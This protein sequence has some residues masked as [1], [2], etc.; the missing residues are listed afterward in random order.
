M[1]GL[2]RNR[3]GAVLRSLLRCDSIIETTKVVPARQSLPPM[4]ALEYVPVPARA[5][6]DAPSFDDLLLEPYCNANI[7]GEA[8]ARLFAAMAE[9][10]FNADGECEGTPLPDY[11][12]TELA[13]HMVRLGALQACE[14]DFG[15]RHYRIRLV[16][17][18]VQIL[19]LVLVSHNEFL[20]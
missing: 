16:L 10:F 18:L 5:I 1:V 12:S 17:V 6:L 9:D 19:V 14:S 2:F 3:F 13:E 7:S 4:D 8:E 11:V 15:E 20:A